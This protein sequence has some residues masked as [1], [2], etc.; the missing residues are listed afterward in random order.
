MFDT[1]KCIQG[2]VLDQK[3]A[4]IRREVCSMSTYC[5]VSRIFHQWHNMSPSPYP[6]VRLHVRIEIVRS[7]LH[8]ATLAITSCC[9]YV[10]AKG[11]STLV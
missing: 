10:H 8:R 3:Y 9:R 4:A 1:G 2:N 6:I 7:I 11:T 5:I